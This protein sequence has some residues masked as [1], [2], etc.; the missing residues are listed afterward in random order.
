MEHRQSVGPLQLRPRSAVA[1]SLLSLVLARPLSAQIA[2]FSN[3]AS[4]SLE[5]SSPWQK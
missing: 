1:V 5:A 4:D 2:D 3:L